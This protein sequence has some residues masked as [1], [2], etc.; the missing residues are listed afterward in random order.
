MNNISDG[1]GGGFDL[2]DFGATVQHTS[3]P[4]PAFGLNG[5]LRADGPIASPIYHDGFAYVIT[6]GGTL[7]TFDLKAKKVANVEH[8]DTR[9][10][11]SG[12]SVGGRAG[13]TASPAFVGGALYFFD[14]SGNTLIREP[15]PNGK[16][17]ARHT[18]LLGPPDQN[19]RLS[20]A[21]SS[22]VFD[23]SRIY[24]RVAGRLYC[25]GEK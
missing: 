16:V 11:Y 18:M 13:I 21:N 6:M 22:P 9:T 5:G 23:G 2:V 7:V 24:W 4:W 3:I 10:C 1:N 19:G 12:T 8:L 17:L 25:I 20:S 15:G 14:D